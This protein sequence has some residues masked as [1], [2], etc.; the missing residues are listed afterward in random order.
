[1]LDFAG[2]LKLN[3]VY[4]VCLVLALS[5]QYLHIVPVSDQIFIILSVIGVLPVLASA[6]KALIKRKFTIDLLA[7]IALVFS[8]IAGE[9]HSAAF[10][11]LMLSFARIFDI[12]TEMRTKHIIEHLMKYR[13]V[14]VKVKRD[15]E[16]IEIPV[17]HVRIHDL[18]VIEAGERIP[19][20]GTV[21]S[22]AASVNES[23]LTGES[24]LVSKKKGSQVYTSTLN[25]SGTLIVLAEKIGKDSTLARIILLIEEASRNKAATERVADAFTQWYIIIML[26]GSFSLYLFTHNP[27]LV[28][29]I[30]LVICADDIAVAVPLTYT[31]AIA[32]AAKRG[33]LIKGSDV[34]EKL[35]KINIFMTDKTGTLTSGK[36]TIAEIKLYNGYGEKHVYEMLGAASIDSSHPVDGAIVKYLKEKNIKILA[37]DDTKESPGEGLVVK[38]DD[39]NLVIGKVEFLSAK[40]IKYT[41][42]EHKEIEELKAKGYSLS[43]FSIN[44]KLAAL[45]V[46]EDEI[47]PHVR[48]IIEETKRLGVKSW[49]MITGDNERVA[50]RVAKLLSIDG[51]KCNVKPEDK[52]KYAKE[53]K[54]AGPSVLAMV[55]DGVNDAA[56]LALADVSIAMGAIGSDAAI[57]AADVALMNDKLERIPEAMQIGKLAMSIVKQNFVIWAITNSIGLYLVF[58]HH[59]DPVGA[60]TYNFLTDFFPIVNALRVMLYRPKALV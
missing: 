46:F 5:A 40:G 34:I 37:P 39:D 59:L 41:E 29:S 27:S 6:V 49:T 55:G 52:L 23:T 50:S 20:D 16:I 17:E 13:P 31:L 8:F 36:P 26:V 47:R 58:V 38:K 45:V 33:I 11:N 7:S 28:L 10:I 1:M 57:E 44:H 4:A 53:M 12:W 48:R 2:N 35:A 21:M 56:A 25:E 9:W 54:R 14:E 32:R 19:V 15:T 43:A 18:V 24:E 22:G 30:L 60:S 51:Y 3:I 42:A